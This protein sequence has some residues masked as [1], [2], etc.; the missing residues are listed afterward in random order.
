MKSIT[1]EIDPIEWNIVIEKYLQM[2]G[3]STFRTQSLFYLAEI[4]GIIQ[5]KCWEE[6][7]TFPLTL[8]PS[9]AR[10]FFPFYLNL[11]SLLNLKSV[12]SREETKKAVFDFVCKRTQG[13]I[14]WPQKKRSAGYSDDCF[15]IADAYVLAQAGW[16]ESTVDS[17]LKYYN[18]DQ[19]K[20]GTVS[21]SPLFTDFVKI[22]IVHFIKKYLDDES[23]RDIDSIPQVLIDVCLCGCLHL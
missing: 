19:V 9:T 3:T 18:V 20:E 21:T 2:F 8:H 12:G 10:Y 16:I 11:R 4:N 22:N 6:L 1:T 17:V 7:K 23:I 13:Q 5:Y 14:E 15:D